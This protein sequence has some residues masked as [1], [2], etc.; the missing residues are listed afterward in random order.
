MRQ[1]LGRLLQGSRYQVSRR[2]GY[3]SSNHSERVW[4][5]QSRRSWFQDNGGEGRR[6]P[7]W[8]V[9]LDGG[10][11]EGG[12][13]WR[14]HGKTECLFVRRCS[15]PQKRCADCC[16]LRQRV[17]AEQTFCYLSPCQ[18]RAKGE[19][20][21]F[22][23]FL[24]IEFPA[25]ANHRSHIIQGLSWTNLD[26]PE[27]CTSRHLFHFPLFKSRFFEIILNVSVRLRVHL[28]AHCYN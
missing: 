5:A 12:G 10:N 15:Y 7:I 4:S 23:D 18:L 28:M 8:R 11:F 17:R 22:N 1:L 16:P 6:G 3:S 9:P 27:I 24:K 14:E 20:Y 26:R 2:K 21:S 19:K 13:H 25:E